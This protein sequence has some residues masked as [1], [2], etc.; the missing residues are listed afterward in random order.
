MP[1]IVMFYGI[2][3]AGIFMMTRGLSCRGVFTQ[4][5]DVSPFKQ[6]FVALDTATP[7]AGQAIWIL[8]PKPSMTARRR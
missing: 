4:L 1:T 7:C 6:A 8:P 3:S 2:T 5:P